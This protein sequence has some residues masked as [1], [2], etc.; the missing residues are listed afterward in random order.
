[1]LFQKKFRVRGLFKV[2]LEFIYSVN[3]SS[4]VVLRYDVK[5]DFLTQIVIKLGKYPFPLQEAVIHLTQN[6]NQWIPLST[7][8]D[9]ENTRCL[10]IQVKTYQFHL[11]NQV[12]YLKHEMNRQSIFTLQPFIK[13]RCGFLHL[14]T[15]ALLSS[16]RVSEVIFLLRNFKL[17]NI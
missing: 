1:M 15:H 6:E 3:L 4:Q 2:T 12:S 5:D 11:L 17:K 9:K 7:I 13:L 16:A 14:S 10:G 8:R